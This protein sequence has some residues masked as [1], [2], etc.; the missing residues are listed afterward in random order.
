VDAKRDYGDVEGIMLGLSK[1]QVLFTHLIVANP[2]ASGTKCAIDAGYS[3]ASAAE[4]A[5]ENLKLS[6][7]QDAIQDRRDQLAA[8]AG[9]T[10]ELILREMLQVA[11]ADPNDLVRVVRTCCQ[12]CWA[13]ED[14]E[15]PPNPKCSAC[16]GE[17]LSFVRI[18]DTSKLK[19]AARRL[20]AGAVQTKDGVKVLMRDQ[21]AALRYLADYLGM[22]NKSK[23]EISGPG[24]GPI[25]LAAALVTDLTDAQLMAIAAA[26]LPGLTDNLGVSQGVSQGMLEASTTIEGT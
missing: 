21:D 13:I 15:L 12:L 26:G 11:L 24:G 10:P 23:G 3:P 22:L 9:L 8:A 17:G 20:Y 25:P 2:T 5:S 1:R 4:S 6:K 7:V 14:A 16:K 19:G 18:A